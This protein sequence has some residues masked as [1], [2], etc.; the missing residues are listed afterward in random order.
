MEKLRLVELF[1]GGGT[2]TNRTSEGR[3]E[4]VSKFDHHHL[5]GISGRI[6]NLQVFNNNAFSI[7]SMFNC[8]DVLFYVDPCYLGSTR[9]SSTCYLHELR[10]EQEHRKLAELLHKTR[11]QVVLSGYRSDLYEEL[12]GDWQCFTKESRTASNT[13]KI[14]CLWV[15]RFH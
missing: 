9:A 11:G 5:Y 10:T 7:I 6:Q 8:E 13:T 14:E 1:A 15:N 3:I 12:Y 4:Q 2:T